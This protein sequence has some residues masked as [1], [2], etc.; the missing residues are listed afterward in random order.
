M[1]EEI[2][3]I[4]QDNEV[5]NLVKKHM[6][7]YEEVLNRT[8]LI[9]GPKE[10]EENFNIGIKELE[11]LVKVFFDNDGFP[12]SRNPNDLVFFF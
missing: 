8:E 6:A 10:Y 1:T 3:R 11:T 12:L 9:Q 7:Q 4:D 2:E 5:D